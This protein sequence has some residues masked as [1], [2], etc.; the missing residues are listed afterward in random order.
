MVS[1]EIRDDFIALRE[2]CII[3]KRN[4]DTYNGL[5]F[6]GHDDLLKTVA[7]IFFN[8]IAQIFQR[9]WLLQVTKI[10]DP[11]KVNIG[12]Q[13]RRNISIKLIN[14]HLRKLNLLTDEMDRLSKNIFAYGQLLKPLR[15]RMLAHI[16]RES[17]FSKQVLGETTK[18]ELDKFIIH[19]QQ[20]CDLV[21]IA[22]GEGP[23]DF[24]GSGCSGDVYDLLETLKKL[25]IS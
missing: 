5:F 4:F 3:I 21:G 17:H 8:D 23:L 12:D 2:Q 10:M 1:K 6:S 22:L 13:I 16:D 15:N 7:V 11:A 19:Q 14:T 18:D 9:D 20:Y 24:S 25:Q